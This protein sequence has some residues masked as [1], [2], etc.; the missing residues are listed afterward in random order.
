MAFGD[1]IAPAAAAVRPR[2]KEHF[3]CRRRPD[4]F[5]RIRSAKVPTSSECARLMQ[6]MGSMTYREFR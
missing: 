2:R 1:A 4:V 3:F 6:S 5:E